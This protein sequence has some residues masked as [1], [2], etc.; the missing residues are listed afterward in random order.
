LKAEKL[1]REKDRMIPGI[2]PPDFALMNTK[3]V[4]TD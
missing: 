4:L 2:L 3:T 1:A